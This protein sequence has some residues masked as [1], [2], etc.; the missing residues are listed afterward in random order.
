M[1]PMSYLFPI[2]YPAET[3]IGI[4]RRGNGKGIGEAGN[5][6]ITVIAVLPYLTGRICAG[7]QV[8]VAVI[9]VGDR[10]ATGISY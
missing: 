2:P 6:M 5:P 3:V 7:C 8:E 10:P 4:G 9:A 1:K